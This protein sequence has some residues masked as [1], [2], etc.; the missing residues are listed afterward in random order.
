MGLKNSIRASAFIPIALIF[1][2]LAVIEYHYF[3]GSS[4]EAHLRALRA[5]AIA[6]SELTAHGAAPAVDF[7]DHESLDEYFK[8]AARD[9]ELAYIAVFDGLG[10]LRASFDRA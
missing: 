3:P 9:E 6:V 4:Y 8:G 1:G 7:D 2:L 5:K 10:K